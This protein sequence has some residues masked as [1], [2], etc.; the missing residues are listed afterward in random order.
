VDGMEEVAS[1]SVLQQSY[2]WLCER[3]RDYSPR[4]DVWDLRWRW[5]EIRPHLQAQLRAGAY[6]LGPVR[7]IRHG[8]EIWTAPV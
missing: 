5:E 2:A 8:D 1:E 3:R 7:H 4:D 6:R